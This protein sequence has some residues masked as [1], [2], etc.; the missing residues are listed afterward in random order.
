MI[1]KFLAKKETYSIHK[2]ARRHCPRNRVIVEGLNSMWD[3]DLASMEN[4]SKYDD[5]IK[6]LLVLIDIFSRFLIL[7]PLINKN[8]NTVAKALKS[9]FMEVTEDP[10]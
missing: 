10:K 1:K 6:Y 2:P 8:S 9:I 3:G 4:V 7:K 5:G